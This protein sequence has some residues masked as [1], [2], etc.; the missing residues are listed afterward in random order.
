MLDHKI[1]G[2]K[3]STLP[4]VVDL[5]Q[6]TKVIV[7]GHGSRDRS[8]TLEFSAL[9]EA[10]RALQPALSLDHAYVELA[11]PNIAPVLAEAATCFARVVLV[12]VSLFN[13]GHV[14]N[15][16]PLLVA[17]QRLKTPKVEFVLT[18]PLGAMVEGLDALLTQLGPWAEPSRGATLADAALLVV[19]RGSSDPDANSELY[20]VARLLGEGL[21]LKSVLPCF[22]GITEPRLEAS[23]DWAARLRPK[24]LLVLPYFLF[25][26]VLQKRLSEQVQAFAQQH[27]WIEVVYHGP[28]AWREIL[29]RMI[30][31]RLAEVGAGALPLPCVS[32]HYRAPLGTIASEVGGLN[33]LLL[34]VRRS[35]AHQEVVP[36]VHA[37]KALHKHVLVCTNRECAQRGS[38]TL[39]SELRA[40]LRKLPRNHGFKV[41]RTY[42]M[43]RCGEGPAVAVYP[44]GVWYRGV[45]PEDAAPLVQQH[46]LKDQIL[47]ER[48]D[49]IM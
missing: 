42:C 37:H 1:D 12:P 40:E 35:L 31:I 28:L 18:P 44:D 21:G 3:E 11:E 49:H 45:Q 5:G 38:L 6:D 27:P 9:V 43:G 46:L 48:I 25:N 29:L 14:K 8:A 24:K 16:L 39:L 2:V 34:S 23:L 17:K 20:K 7:V 22:V 30:G 41:T 32:C 13:A 19:G 10:L 15:E 26:G 4:T 36:H 33:A 47:P